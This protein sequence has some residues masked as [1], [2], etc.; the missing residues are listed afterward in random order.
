MHGNENNCLD[1]IP[2]YLNNMI[3]LYTGERAV[4]PQNHLLRMEAVGV[5]GFC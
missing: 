2:E 1:L 5:D 4:Q 3:P